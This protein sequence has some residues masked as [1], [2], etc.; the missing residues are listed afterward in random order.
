MALRDR[1]KVKDR[2]RVRARVGGRGRVRVAAGLTE[3][4]VLGLAVAREV[5][6]VRR[7]VDG[8]EELFGLRVRVRG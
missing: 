2:D 4:V 5:D 7:G 8:A 1:V 3:E 6:D